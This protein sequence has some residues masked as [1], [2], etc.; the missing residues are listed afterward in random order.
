MLFPYFYRRILPMKRTVILWFFPILLIILLIGCKKKEP[1][2]GFEFITGKGGLVQFTNTSGGVIDKFKWDFGDKSPFSNKVNP[3]HRF[4]SAGK[5]NVTLEVTNGDGTGSIT[6]EIEIKSGERVNLGD[7]PAP[8]GVSGY[9]YA[10][11][12]YEYDRNAPEIPKSIRGAALGVFYDSTNFAVDVGKVS[13]NGKDLDENF[14][15]TYSYIS[16]DSSFVFDRD[17]SWRVDGG[18]GFSPIIDNIPGSFPGITSINPRATWTAGTD[19]NY[20]ITLRAPI[21]QAD[22][23]W[24]R[25]ETESGD[26]VLQVNTGSGMAGANFPKSEMSGLSK[27]D[28]VIKVVAYTLYYKNYGFKRVFFTKES[29]VTEKLKVQ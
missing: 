24:W 20:T 23:V 9:A 19:S 29:V 2:A 25:I 12:F 17:V 11:N 3:M 18:N 13:C 7:H 16:P 27:G 26:K 4:L 6:K 21:T 15:N 28:Y 22:S 1:R 8:S 10:R 14:D 5:Y